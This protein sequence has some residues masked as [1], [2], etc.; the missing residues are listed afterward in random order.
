MA[1]RKHISPEEYIEAMDAYLL[2]RIDIK[3]IFIRFHIK[4]YERLKEDAERKTAG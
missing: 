4:N 1:I 3:D 2:G